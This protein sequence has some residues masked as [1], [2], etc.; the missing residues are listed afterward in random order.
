MWGLGR[1]HVP[2][3]SI[4][5]LQQICK[6][7]A[8]TCPKIAKNTKNMQQICNKYATNMQQICN[9]YAKY[10]QQVYWKYAT[11]YA[12]NSQNTSKIYKI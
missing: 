3:S 9:K 4:Y 7:Y 1:L 8:K 2:I 10:I 5:V 11:K 6:L 12:R